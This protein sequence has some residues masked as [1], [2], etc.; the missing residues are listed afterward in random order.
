MMTEKNCNHKEKHK[1]SVTAVMLP[2]KCGA[3]LLKIQ[4]RRI[5]RNMQGDDKDTCNDTLT[6]TMI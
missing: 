1:N 5:A 2:L 3:E 6:H 4:I